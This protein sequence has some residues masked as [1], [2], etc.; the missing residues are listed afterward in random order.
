MPFPNRDSPLISK[1]YLVKLQQF[2]EK[3]INV[4]RLPCQYLLMASRRFIFPHT[5]VSPD[6]LE[7]V[8]I[9]FQ[10][11]KGEMMKTKT[12]LILFLSIMI[13]LSAQGTAPAD[14]DGDGKL[15]VS[16]KD[17]LLYLSQNSSADW[18]ANYEQ[19]DNIV[20]EDADFQSGG[21]FYNGGAGFSPIGNSSTEFSGSY[22]GGGYTIDNLYINRPSTE[23]IA[24]FGKTD[25][26]TI[27]SIGVTNV[28]IT[29][30]NN[31]G[32]LVGWHYGNTVSYSYTTGSVHGEDQGSGSVF[33]PGIYV[34]GFIGYINGGT[35]SNSYSTASVSGYGSIGGLIGYNS[36]TISKC[37]AGGSVSGTEDT[38]G[39]VGDSD[40]SDV[41]DS[42]WDE[43]ASGQ[44]SSSGGA[45]AKTT[46]EMKDVATFTDEGTSGLDNAWDF[47]TNPNDDTANSDYWD[48]DL[49]GSTNSG[50]PFLSWQN[51]TDTSLPVSLSTFTAKAMNGYVQLIWA[52]DSEIENLGFNIYRA[53]GEGTFQLLA[54]FS[55]HKALEGSGST[56]G[57]TEYAFQDARVTTG[58]T[59]HYLLADVDYSGVEKRH[60]D[61]IVTLTYTPDAG[62]KEPDVFS[63]EQVYPNPFNP[64]T[65]IEFS[66]DESEKVNLSIYDVRGHVVR[67]LVNGVFSAGTHAV[68]WDA[69]D[70]IGR[71]LGAGL[72]FCRMKVQGGSQMK[73]LVLLR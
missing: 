65:V 4:D 70:D 13:R 73:T 28:D 8:I 62:T 26:A 44:S 60:E 58:S 48:M 56:N 38:G 71:Q 15:E 10:F 72:Y 35:I 29:G 2:S 22:D 6:F 39:L 55:H 25:G 66:L 21:D 31:V 9:T 30:Q 57:Y 61:R 27:T 52:T 7:L 47:E 50:Y 59:Y 46:S 45:T 53:Q 20:F 51:G 24:L 16:S 37:Y 19:T 11:S 43:V 5:E 17:N 67:T 36:G 33:G 34:G 41:Y 64:G 49:S 18:S 12:F 63:L 14:G 68:I 23:Y 3:W 69:R 40:W 54:S 1:F 32:G 42:F